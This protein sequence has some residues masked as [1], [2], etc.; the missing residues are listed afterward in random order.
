M[1]RGDLKVSDM[2]REQW[3]WLD[4]LPF[5]MEVFY[6]LMYSVVLRFLFFVYGF[7]FLSALY[8]M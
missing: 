7:F 2:V 1:L 3:G 8:N 5:A 6:T 4:V